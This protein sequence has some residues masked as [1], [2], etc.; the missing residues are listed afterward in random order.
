MRRAIVALLLVVVTVSGFAQSAVSTGIYKYTSPTGYK[1]NDA[2]V[3]KGRL[4]FFAPPKNAYSCNVMI[5]TAQAGSFTAEKIGTDTVAYLKQQD[6]ATSK[7]VGVSTKL[8]GKPGYSVKS[9]RKLPNGMIIDQEQVIG[10]YKGTAIILT[11]SA[12]VD[13]FAKENAKFRSSLSSW[14]WLN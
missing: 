4:G 7:I 14:K 2:R 12:P 3:P 11:F 8:G 13:S 9:R 10:V 1:R 6:K 5:S